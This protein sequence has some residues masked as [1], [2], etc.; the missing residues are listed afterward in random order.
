MYRENGLG[1][2]VRELTFMQRKSPT[3][4]SLF[5]TVG[6]VQSNYGDLLKRLYVFTREQQE[7]SR[8]I[9]AFTQ[10]AESFQKLE[11]RSR[12]AECHWKTADAYD[13]L[14]EH[15]QSAH[16]FDLASKN[17][18]RAAENMPQLKELYQDQALYMQ[19][20]SEIEKARH[21]HGRQEYGL[22]EEHFEK[23]AN[24]HKSLKKWSYLTPNYA[25]W[26]QL[27]HAEELSRKE[28]SE[29]ALRAFE[30]AVGLFE[31]TKNSLKTELS[32][33]EDSDEK[34]MATNML[35]ATDLRREYCLSRIDVEE[36]RIL[37][38]KGD[39]SSSSQKYRSA[40]ETLEKIAS[41]MESEQDKKEFKLIATLSRAWA[42]MT[43]AEAE[44]NPDLYAEASKL[45]EEAKELSPNEKTRILA[46]GHSRFCKALE[47]GTKFADTRT[48]ALHA[49]AIQ[50]LESAA[51]YYVK[52]DF[53]N[54]AEYAKATE[55]LL[56]AYLH[57]DNAKK[58]NDPEKKAK[59]YMMTEKVLQT[60]AGS[61]MKAEHPEKREQ[62]L[63]LLDKVKEE[64][65]LAVSLSEV[66]HAPPIV[67]T[68]TA[69]TTPTP[70][71]ENAVGLVRFENADIQ[72]NIL[73]REKNLKVGENLDLEIELVNAG[74]SP[75]LLVKITKLVPEGFELVQKP[76]TYRIE[77]NYLNL[78][79]KRL[80]PLK[81]EELK[82]TLKAKVQGEFS[83]TPAILYL[84]ENGKYKSHTPQPIDIT[85]KELGIKGW[86]KG[87]K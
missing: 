73:I 33:I 29:E 38:K 32:K 77:D 84:D 46:L 30:Q 42:K 51:T 8:A 40:A 49:T 83:L 2:L 16:S 41:A 55:L 24:L 65:E 25:A 50:Q 35:K 5:S 66:L 31:E 64:R 69:F 44:E 68:T 76:E 18:E 75:A 15:L 26:T 57:M 74:K 7:M 9:E 71:Q 56:D 52:A 20:W 43:Q 4:S 39:H 62:V 3:P 85:V 45:F 79:G 48:P 17:Y 27:E 47:A 54:A 13:T 37:D 63:R 1:L 80:D 34:Q 23:A 11:L 87:D 70:T 81:T 59:L 28:K 78:K 53:Q 21:H 58:E 61:F 36:A 22:A 72:A 86:L 14:G 19:A 12:M 67:S 60:S 10:A 82:L 6:D